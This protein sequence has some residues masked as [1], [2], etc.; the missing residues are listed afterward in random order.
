MTQA[1][2]VRGPRRPSTLA[3]AVIGLGAMGAPIARRLSESGFHVVGAD[4]DPRRRALV[5]DRVASAAT[6]AEAV[7]G[8]ELVLL[9]LPT[10]KEVDAVVLGPH[11]VLAHAG[12]GTLVVD[13]TTGQPS[14]TRR[15]GTRLRHA[16]HDMIDA[17]VSGGAAAAA[18]GRLA[19][20]VGGRAAAIDRARPVLHALAVKVVHCGDLGAGSVVKLVNNVLVAA[21]LLAAAEA[22]R[23]G[24]AEGLDPEALL[25]AVNAGSGA[26]QV[27]S[28]NWPEWIQSGAF[29]SGFTVGLMRKDVDLALEVADERRLGVPLLA[30]VRD[31]WH[32]GEQELGPHADFNL[33]AEQGG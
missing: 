15:I 19:V 30:R 22:L 21:H 12:P 4:D 17:P 29:D 2:D 6:V 23:I 32:A 7:D 28:H 9:S 16:G 20:M 10:S 11:G 25:A 5:E 33:I 31:L 8:A 18:A 24:L 3:L 14:E 27:T 26:S 1:A 13:M